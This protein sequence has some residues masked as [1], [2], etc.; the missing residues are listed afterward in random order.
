[1]M[2]SIAALALTV[3]VTCWLHAQASQ[4][5]AAAPPQYPVVTL[6]FDSPQPTPLGKRGSVMLGNATC[7]PDGTLFM[8]MA[9]IPP[10]KMDYTLYSLSNGTKDVRYAVAMVPGYKSVG[11]GFQYFASDYGVVTVV[12]ATPQKTRWRKARTPL[13]RT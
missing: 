8:E 6:N 7:A 9:A 4:P 1:M 5:P 13:R 11:F 10:E 3:A 12:G 2:R